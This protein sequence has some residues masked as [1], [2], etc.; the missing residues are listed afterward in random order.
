[1]VNVNIAL[2]IGR[3]Q[4]FHRGHYRVVKDLKQKYTP[5]IGIGS[6]EKMNSFENPLSFNERRKMVRSCFPGT[7]VFAIPDRGDDEL[8]VEEIVERI[9][10]KVVVTGNDWTKR[11]FRK[12]GYGTERPRMYNRDKYEGTTIRELAAERNEDWKDL[13]PECSRNLLENFN[14]EE[15]MEELKGKD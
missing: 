1:M 14:F 2:F 11:C 7:D 3:F 10:F 5:V 13:V 6:S 8:W 9:R 12:K 4:P 15:R